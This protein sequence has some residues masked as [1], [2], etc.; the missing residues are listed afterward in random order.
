MSIRKTISTVAALALATAVLG[1]SGGELTD[2][3]AP[4][5]LVATT[6]Q[7]VNV[8]DLNPETAGID[9]DCLQ[10]VGF[11]TLDVLTK[12][13]DDLSGTASTVRVNRY[14]VSYQR[15]DGGTLV[16]APFVRP[17]DTIIP[18][19]GSAIF[20]DLLIFE[21]DAANQAPFVAL[22]PE[23]GGRDPVTN[24]PFVGLDVI[25]EFYGETLGGD[26]VYDATRFPL[27]F[28]YGCGCT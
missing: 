1:C 7:N 26:N 18:V 15:R 24:R 5:T 16:P 3:A 13:R 28:C 27:D 23:N 20:G 9:V 8:F 21:P 12:G 17:I 4:V 22:R 10:P 25:L 19:G 14:R 11:I 2:D 6:E